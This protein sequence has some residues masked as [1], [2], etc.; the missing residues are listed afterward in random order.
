[1][2][3]RTLELIQSELE[4]ILVQSFDQG[5]WSTETRQR[6]AELIYLEKLWL[7]GR[8]PSADPVAA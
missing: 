6:Y 5:Q 3:T 4:E 1:M 7:A 2:W 8:D